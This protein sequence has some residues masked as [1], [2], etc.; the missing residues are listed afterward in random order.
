MPLPE[1]AVL[2]LPETRR[3]LVYGS[4]ALFGP[5]V[6]YLAL[7]AGYAAS[8][9]VC[10]PG[11]RF[12]LGSSVLFGLTGSALAAMAS[13]LWLRQ[14]RRDPEQWNAPRAGF[15]LSSAVAVNAVSTLLMIG[16]VIALFTRA[17]CAG[18]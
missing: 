11:G 10:E 8:S 7:L 3:A 5:S 2:T 4:L 6:W 17:L 16:F 18:S 1:V 15:V 9:R 13:A 12:I 14:F